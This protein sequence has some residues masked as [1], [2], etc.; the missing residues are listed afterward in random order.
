MRADLTA[1]KLTALIYALVKAFDYENAWRI[2]GEVIENVLIAR[3]SGKGE[4][5]RFL[6][7]EAKRLEDERGPVR[8]AWLLALEGSDLT[9]AEN[10]KGRGDELRYRNVLDGYE[11]KL[12]I[13]VGDQRGLIKKI[14]DEIANLA[15]KSYEGSEYHVAW[16]MLPSILTSL[17]R[18]E[19]AALI[20]ATKQ[21]PHLPVLDVASVTSAIASALKDGEIGIVAF[22]IKGV[23]RYISSSRAGRD[24]WASSFIPSLLTLYVITRLSEELGPD[25]FLKPSLLNMPLYDLWLYG[26]NVIERPELSTRDIITPLIPASVIVLCQPDKIDE[27][28]DK[29]LRFYREGW[30]KLASTALG[31][32]K[33]VVEELDLPF[34][35]ALTSMRIPVD[36]E[37]RKEV[38][39]PLKEYG[40]VNTEEPLLPHFLRIVLRKLALTGGAPRIY[41]ISLLSSGPLEISRRG[42]L[43]SMCWQRKMITDDH[44]LL[45]EN[46]RLCAHCL[47]KRMLA[48]DSVLKACLAALLS[49]SPEGKNRIRD[50]LEDILRSNLPEREITLMDIPSIDTLATLSFKMT[51]IRAAEK[52]SEVRFLAEKFVRKWDNFMNKLKRRQFTLPDF[53]SE[54]A[55]TRE[56]L[57]EDL[58]YLTFIDGVWL[59]EESYRRVMREK[60]NLRNDAQEL[61]SL[62]DKIRNTLS[63]N[64][65]VLSGD[66]GILSESQGR[67]FSIV[68]GDGDNMGMLFSMEDRYA[69]R[70]SDV[71][72]NIG[73]EVG[74]ERYTPS[75]AMTASLSRRLTALA[76]RV[77]DI[78]YEHGIFP[79]FLGGDD[80]LLL[81]PVE[82]ALVGT[83][84]MRREFSQSML[85]VVDRVSGSWVLVPGLGSKASQTFSIRTCH[86][87]S[88]LKLELERASMDEERGKYV[89]LD[90]RVKNALVITYKPRGR[91]LKA[92]L[93]WSLF[94]D[95]LSLA[96]RVMSLVTI[97]LDNPSLL[98]LGRG[99]EEGVSLS[100]LTS[101]ISRRAY[102]DFLQQ[103]KVFNVKSPES[104][105]LIS[106]L[107]LKKHQS[108][109][110][111]LSNLL[112]DLKRAACKEILLRE[113]GVERFNALI[114]LFKA[115][116]CVLEPL[117]SIVKWGER[118]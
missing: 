13:E 10:L 41:A 94:E 49:E 42:E 2:A 29:V 18:S 91:E 34:E 84:L 6:G 72:P 64:V 5:A 75:L 44:P 48:V 111:E 9:I 74:G 27:V 112:P 80:L 85:K 47:V 62:L 52:I 110:V 57:K 67:Y 30:R 118:I 70:I 12:N 38:V 25:S 36:A 58:L 1:R 90:G 11:R 78:C 106:R 43:C 82:T 3:L 113:D 15:I 20:P 95:P 33:G 19:D 59:L 37:R 86:R 17:M 50:L 96:E 14:V 104:L 79:V 55:K 53:Y 8:L 100:P 60:S 109:R 23:Q 24:M 89:E 51:L 66:K 4:L 102:I 101:S 98:T 16:R 116:L 45:R 93:S 87:M 99:V 103:V 108:A 39:K 40:L 92:T 107:E 117:P 54:L 63:E 69:V 7:E 76:M 28:E 114:E 46:E 31:E 73:G 68:R 88:P 26:L 77:N 71:A 65:E 35:V 105:Y 56:R 22:E 32:Y 61:I 21:T 97:T 81:S 115:A 83:A